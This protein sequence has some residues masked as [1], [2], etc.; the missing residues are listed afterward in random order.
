[1]SVPLSDGESYTYS[2]APQQRNVD[3]GAALQTVPAGQIWSL[4]RF[5][6]FHELTQVR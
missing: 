5:F 1:M 3:E 2:D 6:F 4:R